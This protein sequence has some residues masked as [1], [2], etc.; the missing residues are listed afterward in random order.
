MKQTILLKELDHPNIPKLYDVFTENKNKIQ[1]IREFVEGQPITK[2]K[3]KEMTIFDV[4]G[5]L[6]ECVKYLHSK[7]IKHSNI[8][9]TT[10]FAKQTTNNHIEVKLLKVECSHYTTSRQE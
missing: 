8:T 7:G 2:Y 5:Q 9:N 1:M 3:L 10:V 4:A 6:L